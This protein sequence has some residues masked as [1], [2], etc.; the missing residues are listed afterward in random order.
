MSDSQLT[1]KALAQSMKE[2]MK[3]K[4]M[5]KISISDIVEGCNINRQSFYYHFKDKYDLVN[6]IFYTE[7]VLSLQDVPSEKLGVLEKTCQYFYANKK[8]YKNAFEVVGQNSFSEYFIE[9]IQPILKVQLSEIFKTKKD[10]D[11]YATFYA[12]AIRLS[13]SRWLIEGAQIPPDKFVELLRNAIEGV[14]IYL[15]EE[16]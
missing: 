12:D 15:S 6:W 4:P 7:L 8:F 2:L 3:K 11:F 10:V 1:K 5:K 13:I 9:I 16:D 14:A